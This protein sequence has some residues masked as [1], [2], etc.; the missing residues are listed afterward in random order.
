MIKA[1]YWAVIPAAGIGARMGSER[2]KQY[3]P[4]NG[5]AVIEHS[6][7]C[8]MTH[9]DIAGVLVALAPDDGYGKNLLGKFSGQEK[10]FMTVNGGTERYHSVLNAYAVLPSLRRQATGCWCTTPCDPVCVTKTS[11]N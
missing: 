4:L 9:P 1:K 2:P 8:L 6:L 7:H 3:L 10:P 5:K 11:I